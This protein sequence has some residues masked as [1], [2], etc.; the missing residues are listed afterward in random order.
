MIYPRSIGVLGVGALAESMVKGLRRGGFQ[1]AIHLS[2]RG[3]SRSSRLARTL[4]CRVHQLNQSVVD[5]SDLVVI[6]VRP[7]ALDE[8]FSEVTIPENKTVLS[9]VAGVDIAALARFGP[10]VPIHRAMFTY[11][12]ELGQSTVSLY[13]GGLQVDALLSMLG[14]LMV[15]ESEAQLDVAVSGTCMNGW[16]YFF[17]SELIDWFTAQGLTEEQAER[18]VLGN[19]QDVLS[20]AVSRRGEDLRAMGLKIATPGTRTLLGLQLL[21]EAQFVRPWITALSRTVGREKD[22]GDGVVEHQGE[23]EQTHPE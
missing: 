14:P 6:S 20:R 2:K 19:V 8:L 13:P 11:A 4:D 5:R 22:S 3:Q 18:M 15:L 1:G 9:L 23:D 17:F 7:E 16:L 10:N 12:A 21:E